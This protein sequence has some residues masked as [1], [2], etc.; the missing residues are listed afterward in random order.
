MPKNKAYQPEGFKQYAGLDK[1]NDLN[2]KGNRT[3][4]QSANT[5]NIKK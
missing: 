4:P 1:E 3:T 2:V 5:G